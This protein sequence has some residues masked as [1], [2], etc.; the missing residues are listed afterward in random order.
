MIRECDGCRL[1]YG[2]ASGHVGIALYRAVAGC[3]VHDQKL[4]MLD[5]FRLTVVARK[6]L[7]NDD[8]QELYCI[9][10]FCACIRGSGG[11]PSWY[12]ETS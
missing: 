5:P 8:T 1:A 11:S 10:T 12:T 3:H 6:P 4:D 2:A 9:A 7:S